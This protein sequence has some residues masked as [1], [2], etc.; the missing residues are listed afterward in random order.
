[1]IPSAIALEMSE[2]DVVKRAGFP[3]RVEIGANERN[4]RT[5]TLTYIGGARPG[6]YVFVDGRLTSME[7]G[8]EPV[9]AGKACEEARQARAQAAADIGVARFR[10]DK[11]IPRRLRGLR[12]R[13]ASPLRPWPAR[14][15]MSARDFDMRRGLRRIAR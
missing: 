4:E 15:R 7:R 6:I 11:L 2:C 12:R 8:P 10:F 13:R 9:D 3:E 5:A 14:R 1:M